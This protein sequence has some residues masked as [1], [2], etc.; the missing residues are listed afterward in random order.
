[1]MTYQ[2]ENRKRT[3]DWKTTDYPTLSLSLFIVAR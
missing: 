1:M 3:I 2:L